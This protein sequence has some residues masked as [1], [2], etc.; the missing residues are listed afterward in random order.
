MV[1]RPGAKDRAFTFTYDSVSQL[2][3]RTPLN[4][5]RIIHRCP[6]CGLTLR[7]RDIETAVQVGRWTYHGACHLIAQEPEERENGEKQSNVGD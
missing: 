2:Q 1:S 7:R 3:G 4:R 5:K 6:Y